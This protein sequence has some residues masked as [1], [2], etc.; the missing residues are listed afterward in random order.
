[1][2]AIA[3][4]GT[5][6]ALFATNDHTAQRLARSRDVQVISLQAILRGLWVSGMRSKADVRD[7]LD[8][9]E[10]ADNLEVSVEVEREIFGDDT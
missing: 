4:C 1:L 6:G 7:L 5:E 3:F 8:R 10:G 9:I 2:E